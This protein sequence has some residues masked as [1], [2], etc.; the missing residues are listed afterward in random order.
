[1]KRQALHSK[2]L[3]FYHPILEKEMSFTIKLP[4]DMQEVLRHT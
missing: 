1:M 2:S 4:S 3:T